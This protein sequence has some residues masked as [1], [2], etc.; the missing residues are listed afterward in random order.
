MLVPVNKAFE[1]SI[2]YVYKSRFKLEN[3]VMSKF[4]GRIGELKG[5]SEQLC[6]YMKSKNMEK[7]TDVYYLVRNIYDD[8]CIIDLYIGTSVNIL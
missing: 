1:S 6:S 7:I 4:S 8:D 5:F 2:R 3:A